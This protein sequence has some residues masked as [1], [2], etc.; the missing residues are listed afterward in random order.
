MEELNKELDD[1]VRFIINSYDYKKCLEIKKQMDRNDDVKELIDI[2][3][4]LQKEYVKSNYDADVGKELDIVNEKLN[5][6]P[7]YCVY[8]SCLSRVNNMIDYIKSS[9]NIYF[10]DLLN[11]K[12]N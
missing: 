12:R 11:D 8:N 3:K 7:I 9:L 10:D 1:L 4:R 5:N 6:V 2:V